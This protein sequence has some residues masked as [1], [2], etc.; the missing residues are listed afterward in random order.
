MVHG[1]WARQDADLSYMNQPAIATMLLVAGFSSLN[2]HYL[3][4][5][6]MEPPKYCMDRLFVTPEGVTIDEQVQKLTE[7]STFRVMLHLYS[8]TLQ[9][10]FSCTC[11]TPQSLSQDETI[12]PTDSKR[13]ERVRPVCKVY[14][15]VVALAMQLPAAAPTED[16]HCV[17]VWLM[18]QHCLM[19]YACASACCGYMQVNR[20]KGTRRVTNLN[21]AKYFREIGKAALQALPIL[22]AQELI[23]ATHP[24]LQLSLIHI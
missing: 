7:V 11:V 13:L 14:F 24:V 20:E 19:M 15:K 1:H 10:I 22:Q 21:V 12:L 23:P 2:T 6:H 3:S 8:F 18:A 9:G 5:A 16:A 4:W 17:C